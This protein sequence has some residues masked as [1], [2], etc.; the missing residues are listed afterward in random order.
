MTAACPTSLW[1]VLAV[2]DAMTRRS[3]SSHPIARFAPERENA[4][5]LTQSERSPILCKSLYAGAVEV[6]SNKE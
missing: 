4:R 3:P 5:A 2:S 6:I 1:T